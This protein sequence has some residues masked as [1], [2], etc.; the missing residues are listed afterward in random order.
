MSGRGLAALVAALAAVAC[1]SG[2][3]GG[4]GGGGPRVVDSDERYTV[5]LDA[6]PPAS[7]DAPGELRLRVTTAGGWEI[8]DEAPTHLVLTSPVLGFAPAELGFE[9]ARNLHAGGFE[10][11]TAIR[12]EREGRQH[13]DAELRFGV[14]EKGIQICEVVQTEL[15]LPVVVRFA[16]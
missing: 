4:A 16:E 11:V 9:H 12:S 14:C 1:G 2:D 3:G 8:A 7:P 13:A 10:F 15:E 6:S 5:T